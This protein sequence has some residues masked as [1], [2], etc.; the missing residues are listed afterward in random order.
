M[1]K[2]STIKPRDINTVIFAFTEYEKYSDDKNMENYITELSTS[3]PQFSND[4][5]KNYVTH[6]MERALQYIE[7]DS[8]LPKCFLGSNIGYDELCRLFC[9]ICRQ[10]VTESLE[11]PI[12]ILDGR[13]VSFMIDLDMVPQHPFPQIVNCEKINIERLFSEKLMHAEQ[14]N[15]QRHLAFFAHVFKKIDI[16]RRRCYI[17]QLIKKSDVDYDRPFICAIVRLIC[18][19]ESLNPEQFAERYLNNQEALVAKIIK[20]QK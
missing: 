20:M 17:E 5:V 6:N 16:V 2:L 8:I 15:N 18:H 11:K 19:D 13:V 14:S 12:Q 4:D 10:I 7:K 1:S 3:F 9:C